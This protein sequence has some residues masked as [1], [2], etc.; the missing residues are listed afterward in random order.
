[1]ATYIVRRLLVTIPVL[2]LISL[3]TFLA[4][5][6]LPGD[7]ALAMLGVEADPRHLEALREQLGLNRPVVVRY[8]DWVGDALQ[9]D[10]GYSARAGQEVSDLIVKRL[11]VSIELGILA[12]LV[13]L[14]IGIPLGLLAGARPNTGL[15]YGGTTLAVLGAAIPNFWLA[16]MLILIFAVQLRWFPAVG[17][18]SFLDDPVE[19]LRSVALPAFAVGVTQAAVLA[20]QTRAALV[21]VL[22]QDYVRTAYAKGL[23]ERSVIVRHAFRNALI[24]V[25]TVLGIQ[26]STIVGGFVIVETVFNLPGVGKL[27][28]DSAFNRELPTVQAIGVLLAG[29]VALTNLAVDV[30]YAFLDPRIR[31]E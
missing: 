10:L 21:D 17:F 31:Y 16:L 4:V 8:F 15:D 3:I 2:I 9:G 22:R 18:T 5:A 14:A 6:L 23:R 1:M 7:L 30:S 12:M 29:A 11:E 13:A 26:V 19:N 25:V 28:V 27:L 24:P 20:R